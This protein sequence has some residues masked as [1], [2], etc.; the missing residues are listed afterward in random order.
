MPPKITDEGFKLNERAPGVSVNEIVKKTGA[1]LIV[2]DDT[3]E[4]K[5]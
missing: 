5:L 4:M 1:K 3:P 2:G